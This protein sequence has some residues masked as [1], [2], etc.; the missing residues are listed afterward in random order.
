MAKIGE[1]LGSLD[2]EAMIGG[3]LIA[4]VNAQAQSSMATVDFIHAV[5]FDDDGELVQTAFKYKKD[6][7]EL[8]QDGNPTGN[9]VTKNFELS[10][11]FLTMLPIPC[12]RIEEAT[13]DFN[14]KITSVQYREV[15]TQTKVG[16]QTEGKFGFLFA[17]A[18][19]KTNFSYQRDTKAGNKTTRTYS[20]A[21][22]VRA[23]G[24]ELP[25]GTDR[26]LGILENSIKET[27]Q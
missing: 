11:P 6:I 9:I 26:L 4:C 14:A 21:V 12:L 18:K 3:P 7:E 25:A 10:V 13:V 8:D 5:G 17:S 16:V 23:V 22:H 27:E 24:D 1:E 15:N 2:F 19:L 20:L